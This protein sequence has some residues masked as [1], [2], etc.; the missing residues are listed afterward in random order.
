[1]N[2]YMNLSLSIRSL[3]WTESCHDF[4]HDSFLCDIREPAYAF[5][6]LPM[7]AFMLLNMMHTGTLAPAYKALLGTGQTLKFSHCCHDIG[8]K[9]FC[10]LSC[11]WC[12]KWPPVD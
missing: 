2:E 1:M 10:L 3:S 4:D 8:L 9:V 11:A 6:N 7:F 12:P 5:C